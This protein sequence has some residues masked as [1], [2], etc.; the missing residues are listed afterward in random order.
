MARYEYV[1]YFWEACR[2]GMIEN[3]VAGRKEVG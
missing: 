1:M 2:I 3:N